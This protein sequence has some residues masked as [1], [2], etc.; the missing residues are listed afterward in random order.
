MASSVDVDGVAPVELAVDD[1]AAVGCDYDRCSYIALVAVVAGQTAGCC[2]KLEIATLVL[3]DRDN[4]RHS[5]ST[6]R[7][8]TVVAV[9][10]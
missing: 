7:T 9:V 5:W 1:V 2:N 10:N 6:K 3:D 4:C 8:A